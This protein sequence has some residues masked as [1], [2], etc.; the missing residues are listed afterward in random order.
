MDIKSSC[1]LLQPSFL[2]FY[3][4]SVINEQIQ[5]ILVLVKYLLFTDHVLLI[6]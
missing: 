1:G 3:N 4:F 5:E 6:K 2:A